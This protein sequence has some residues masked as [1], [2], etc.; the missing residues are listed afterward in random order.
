VTVYEGVHRGAHGSQHAVAVVTLAIDHGSAA[1]DL[2]CLVQREA[3]HGIPVRI[4]VLKTT[5]LPS[6]QSSKA[7]PT[8]PS[9][10]AS[11]LSWHANS[12]PGT[13]G[14]VGAVNREEIVVALDLTS[15]HLRPL[16]ERQIGES[17]LG[18]QEI[19][20]HAERATGGSNLTARRADLAREVGAF[21]LQSPLPFGSA[22]ACVTSVTAIA[23][24]LHAPMRSACD[25]RVR[26]CA[27][28]IILW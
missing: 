1:H 16:P 5:Q 3:V 9:I 21:V 25:R 7:R 13:L 4:Q 11:V 15:E 22:G 2:A 17:R 14:P 24:P 26:A 19:R 12:Q 10:H 28:V 18:H 27:S 20:R 6:R 23:L 8:R